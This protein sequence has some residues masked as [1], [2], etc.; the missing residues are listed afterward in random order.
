MKHDGRE[1]PKVDIEGISSPVLL[2]TDN[3]LILVGWYDATTGWWNSFEANHNGFSKETF[4]NVI[5]W[6]D[7]EDYPDDFHIDEE[8][9]R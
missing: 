7:I 6:R 4:G 5:E 8:Q 1:K 2:F 9:Y 3:G